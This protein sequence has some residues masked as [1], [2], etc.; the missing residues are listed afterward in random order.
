MTQVQFVLGARP[1]GH[2]PVGLEASAATESLPAVP[3]P[4]LQLPSLDLKDRGPEGQGALAASWRL[5]R[6]SLENGVARGVP[7]HGRRAQR[8]RAAHGTPCATTWPAD[9]QHV[10]GLLVG[11]YLE[12]ERTSR[13]S[14]P[15]RTWSRSTSPQ[16]PRVEA[17]IS[18]LT[19]C[20]GIEKE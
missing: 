5:P 7:W 11:A 3:R 18:R 6:L 10:L 2:P 1:P 15:A 20:G 14:S 17:H 16:R 13:A 8:H 12:Q 9:G 4:V 19:Q